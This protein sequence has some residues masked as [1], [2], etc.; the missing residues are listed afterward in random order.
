MG[1]HASFSGAIPQHY[2]SKLAPMFFEPYAEDLAGRVPAHAQRVLETATGTGVVTGHLLAR[3]GPDARLFVT[4]RQEAMLD[5][6]RAKFGN[7]PRAEFRVADATTLPF[8]DRSVEAVLCQFGVMF[9]ADRMAGLREAR[10][11][12]THD[13]VFL[14]STWGRLADNPIARA[15]H[16]EVGRVLPHNP[17]AFMELPFSMHDRDEVTDLLHQ[18][19]FTYVRADIVDCIG[20]SESAHHAATGLLCGSPLA[21]ELQERGIPD[22]RTLVDG[23]ALRLAD[24]GGLAPMRLPMRALVFTAQ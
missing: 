14:M 15:A 1:D 13:G 20:E 3:L 4:D 19:G 18:A 24:L 12:L 22:P 23:L 8:D 2:D 7:D 9:F 16:D 11:V 10:R 6:A 5:L 21:L 17:P